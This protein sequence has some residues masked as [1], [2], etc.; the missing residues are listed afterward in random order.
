MNNSPGCE[1]AALARLLWH[2]RASPGDAVCA[3][4]RAGPRPCEEKV[5]TKDIFNRDVLLVLQYCKLVLVS[6]H[7]L[8][9]SSGLGLRDIFTGSRL[10][11][12]LDGFRI[13]RKRLV[14]IQPTL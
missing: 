3:G 11:L 10:D 8:R 6:D 12:P 4:G 7:F 9:V 2:F 14:K 1:V 13:F 5:T